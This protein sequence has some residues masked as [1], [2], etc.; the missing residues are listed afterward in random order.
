MRFEVSASANNIR[1]GS[2][3]FQ[4]AFFISRRTNNWTR[5]LSVMGRMQGLVSAERDGY[6]EN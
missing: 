5:V 4:N 2:R 6:F 1:S 3:I